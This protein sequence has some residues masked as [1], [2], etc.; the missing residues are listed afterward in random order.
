MYFKYENYYAGDYA[1]FRWGKKAQKILEDCLTPNEKGY[2]TLPTATN[3]FAFGY[4]EGKYGEYTKWGETYLSVNSRGYIWAKVGTDK[5]KA[6]I[7]MVTAVLNRMK[8]IREE[9]ARIN[10]ENYIANLKAKGII[11]DEDDEE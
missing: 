4:S 11:D 3:Y 6:F 7:E 2:Y 9:Q 1:I 8:E 5:E 10:D